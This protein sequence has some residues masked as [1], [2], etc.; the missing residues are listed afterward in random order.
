MIAAVLAATDAA[1]MPTQAVTAT[2]VTAAGTALAEATAASPA[3]TP[4]SLPVKQRLVATDPTTVN[5]AA[6]RPQLDEIPV[7]ETEL[8]PPYKVLIHNKDVTYPI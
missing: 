2:E 8:E 6:G 4:I 1:E 7:A 5:L 3:P